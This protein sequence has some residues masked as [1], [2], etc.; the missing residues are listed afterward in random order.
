MTRSD[1][2]S[3]GDGFRSRLVP[4]RARLGV[5]LPTSNR[6][7]EPQFHHFSPDCL[8]VHFARARM[9]GKW[10]KPL[11]DLAPEVAR[12]ASTLADAKP[13]LIV[14]NCTATS[15]MGG[16]E[17]DA[18]LV[19]LVEKESG[20]AALSTAGAVKAAFETLNV[21]RATLVTPY[22][23]TTNDHEIAYFRALGIEILRDVALGLKGG[24]D[25]LL[26]PP[27]Q[28]TSLALANDH[29]DSQCVFMSC[30]NT[31]QIEAIEDIEAAIGKPAV[32]ANQAV[33]WACLQRLSEKLGG[34]QARP[35]PGRLGR[36]SIK[37]RV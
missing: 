7:I 9:T 14:F 17:G 13:D 5:I 28:W 24:D 2:P 18:F 21:R 32:S 33:L 25:Y 36:L 16:P 22:V 12:A 37:T 11:S 35:L 23:Q 3:G 34:E 6:M 19:D 15:M 10:A 4:A 29:P 30:T 31:T 8:G 1:G 20:V 26:L 27:E